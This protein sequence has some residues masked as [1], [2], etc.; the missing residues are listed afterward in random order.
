MTL[1][2]TPEYFSS[3]LSPE[4]QYYSFLCILGGFNPLFFYFF[5][6]NI[7]KNLLIPNF[8]CTFAAEML[9]RKIYSVFA[10]VTVVAFVSMLVVKDYHGLLLHNEWFGV[11][12]CCCHLSHNAEDQICVLDGMPLS[13]HSAHNHSS[14]I[15]NNAEDDDCA[16]C[17]FAVAKILQARYVRC[18]FA[19]TCL[20]MLP[21]SDYLFSIYTFLDHCPGRAP[22]FGMM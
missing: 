11:H 10:W 15:A 22:P 9:N 17:H 6:E 5:N 1:H 14:F 8:F 16:I 20:G 18:G 2:V 3:I 7:K 12:A 13:K 4:R 19:A 21:V